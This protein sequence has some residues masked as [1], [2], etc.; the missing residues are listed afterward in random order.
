[1]IV[2]DPTPGLSVALAAAG[3]EPL[4][5]GGIYR[6]PRRTTAA[7]DLGRDARA[8]HLEARVWCKKGDH[9]LVCHPLSFGRPQRYPRGF[10]WGATPPHPALVQKAFSALLEEV[11]QTL[12][13]VRPSR[14][15]FPG[16]GNLTLPKWFT[17]RL[18][19]HEIELVVHG[20]FDR[21]P[22]WVGL[23]P[24]ALED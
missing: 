15:V 1:M 14:V 11:W 24:A 17:S 6:V 18:E 23:D 12:D 3:W 2:Y 13:A 8:W 21:I 4:E 16:G 22:E 5:R 9:V 7:D 20:A 19:E 10:A